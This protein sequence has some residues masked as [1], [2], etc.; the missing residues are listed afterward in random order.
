MRKKR[1]LKYE[2]QN[3]SK[4][5]NYDKNAHDQTELRKSEQVTVQLYGKNQYWK[6]A[7][8][9]EKF[10]YRRYMIE[11]ENGKRLERNR[12]QLRLITTPKH[13][14]MTETNRK[15]DITTI[16]ENTKQQQ[17][18]LNRV[19]AGKTPNRYGEWQLT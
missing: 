3:N 1:K 19:T 6:K 10:E 7:T 16:E 18:G 9:T 17:L 8:V 5:N 12:R 14:N 2:R 11:L 13:S 15:Q 4:R